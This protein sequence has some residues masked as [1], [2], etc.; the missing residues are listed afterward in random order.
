MVARRVPLAVKI[1][2]PVIIALLA[3]SAVGAVG[4]VAASA[5]ERSA[6]SL[7]AHTAQPLYDLAGIRDM[8][9]DMRTEARDLVLNVGSKATGDT[10]SE[11]A[12]TDQEMDRDVT[13]FQASSGKLDAARTAAF[14]DFESGL[15]AYRT[16]RDGQLKAAVEGGHTEQAM[17]LL[18]NQLAEAETT[19]GDGLDTLSSLEQKAAAA[20]ASATHHSATQSRTTILVSAFA[21]LLVSFGIA[22]VIIRRVLAAVKNVRQTLT[23]VANGDLTGTTK[24]SSAD[25]IGDIAN[26]A[27]AAVG[28]VR[29][30]LAAINRSSCELD[31]AAQALRA[32]ATEIAELSE[33]TSTYA[34]TA[35]ASAHVVHAN[36]QAL[37]AGTDQMETS[38]AE[39]SRNAQQAANAGQQA[40][41][42]VQASTATVARLGESST[43]IGEVLKL[44]TSIAQQ[45]NLL[46]LNATIEA[47]RAGEAGKGFAVVAS[48]VKELAQETAR[49]TDDIAQRIAALRSD[50]AQAADAIGSIAQVIVDINQYQTTIASAVEE[51]G[52]TTIEMGRRISA[53]AAGSGAITTNVEDV[54]SAAR[55]TNAKVEKAREAADKLAT[56]SDDL[57]Q[58]AAAFQV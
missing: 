51:Q 31:T 16:L 40:V 14:S 34:S 15:S 50:S 6:S 26:A 13:A 32:V 20:T 47:A 17:A 18:A 1:T 45:T 28:S 4:L 2:A 49:A 19:L 3:T 30:T 35:A 21:G 22:V 11:I 41:S 5:G 58:A 33:G 38:I 29:D 54:A 39:I 42:A 9:G 24:V 37:A 55:A 8:E 44:I 27:D 7:Y 56:I 48:E 25:E 10:A 43:T 36:S 52:S 46:A 57:R 53:A 12:D 23:Q